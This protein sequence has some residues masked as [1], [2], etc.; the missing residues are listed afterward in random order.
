[1]SHREKRIQIALKKRFQEDNY[2]QVS[3]QLTYQA[4]T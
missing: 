1:M 3:N 4:T 2:L